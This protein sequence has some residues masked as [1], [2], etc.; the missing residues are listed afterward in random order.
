MKTSRGKYFCIL[1]QKALCKFSGEELIKEL[2]S[3]TRSY[4][5]LSSTHQDACR[6]PLSSPDTVPV[7]SNLIHEALNRGYR[8]KDL[9]VYINTTLKDWQSMKYLRIV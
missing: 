1:H 2:A 3:T 6:D 9:K 5:R 8:Y 4:L 7:L